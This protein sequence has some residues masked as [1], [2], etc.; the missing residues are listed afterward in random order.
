MFVLSP[1]R[2]RGRERLKRKEKG[3]GLDI[4]IP[5]AIHRCARNG[6]GRDGENSNFGID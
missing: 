5:E 3:G 6:E 1:V 4:F 2:E